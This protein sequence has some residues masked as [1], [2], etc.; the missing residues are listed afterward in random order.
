MIGLMG[1]HWL[2]FV[3]TAIWHLIF[4]LMALGYG[5]EYYFHLSTYQETLFLEAKLTTFQGITRT[6]LTKHG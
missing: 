2:T 3:S 4:S 6:M 5:F 1:F